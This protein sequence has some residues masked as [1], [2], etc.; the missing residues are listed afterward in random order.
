MRGWICGRI[1][2]GNDCTPSPPLLL[3]VGISEDS[4]YLPTPKRAGGEGAPPSRKASQG[5]KNAEGAKR[6][7]V[8]LTLCALGGHN[9]SLPLRG[10]GWGW[11]RHSKA[12]S[13]QGCQGGSYHR[14]SSPSAPPAPS[15]VNNSPLPRWGRGW[16]W[17]RHSKAQSEQRRRAVK[18]KDA[19]DAEG[20]KGLGV[21]LTFRGLGAP[22][23]SVGE[24]PGVEVTS[25]S[26]LNRNPV[27]EDQRTNYDIAFVAPL[28][29]FPA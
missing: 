17:G 7:S 20:A 18:R 21:S 16:G 26:L 28:D 1:I 22:P 23:P 27:T 9:S 19:K 8:N 5:A 4:P 24:G 13:R 10:R 14:Y 2:R 29:S 12:Q 25:L 3:G 15:A 11:G 6:F